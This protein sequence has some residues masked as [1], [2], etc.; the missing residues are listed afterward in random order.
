MIEN[1]NLFL[2]NLKCAIKCFVNFISDKK[3][4]PYE[5]TNKISGDMIE[6][7]S[8]YKFLSYSINVLYSQ[9]FLKK[10][11]INLLEFFQKYEFS[12][13]KDKEKYNTAHFIFNKLLKIIEGNVFYAKF[14]KHILKYPANQLSAKLLKNNRNLKMLQPQELANFLMLLIYE[15]MVQYVEFQNEKFK[16]LFVKYKGEEIIQIFYDLDYFSREIIPYICNN[17]PQYINNFDDNFY[18]KVSSLRIS[19]REVKEL[20]NGLREN[21]LIVFQKPK[22]V[23]FTISN[24]SPLT[25]MMFKEKNINFQDFIKLIIKNNT[26]PDF[27]KNIKSKNTKYMTLKYWRVKIMSNIGNI[28]LMNLGKNEVL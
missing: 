21:I 24:Q 28:L 20:Y 10:G 6:F 9:D 26:W 11:S 16:K 14:S 17:K 8:E 15:P 19:D 22:N 2:F 7:Y 23:N 3:I 27:V 12:W 13:I 25:N 5:I 18:I 1:N 4:E